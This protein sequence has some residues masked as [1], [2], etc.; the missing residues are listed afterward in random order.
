MIGRSPAAMRQGPDLPG[1]ITRLPAGIA[2]NI[3]MELVRFGFGPENLTLISRDAEGDDLIRA[4]C[5][6]RICPA[7]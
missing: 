5:R 2:L 4:W 1:R 7:I 3:A 6:H